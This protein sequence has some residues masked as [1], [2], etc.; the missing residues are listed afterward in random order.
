[1][2][3]LELLRLKLAKPEPIF[4]AL[5]K[6][7]QDVFDLICKHRRTDVSD[8]FESLVQYELN[9]N[10]PKCKDKIKEYVSKTQLFDI[11]YSNKFECSNC[12]EIKRKQDELKSQKRQSTIRERTENFINNFLNPERSFFEETS[13]SQ[14]FYIIQNVLIN[15]D[16]NAIFQYAAKMPYYDFLETPYWAAVRYKVM[17]KS[18]FKCSLCNQNGKLA[19]H[20][21]SYENRGYEIQNQKDLICLCDN[22][23]KKFH[24]IK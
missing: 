16:R 23:H 3:K 22:C 15:C 19:V 6:I 14:Y 5:D 2:N 24:D 18:D 13:K 4:K 20:H 9:I 1:M 21:R 8:Y 10:C 17:Q 12:K 11:A 7:N